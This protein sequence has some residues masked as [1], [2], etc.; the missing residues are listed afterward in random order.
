MDMKKYFCTAISTLCTLTILTSL[1]LFANQRDSF[2]PPETTQTT[3]SFPSQITRAG[4]TFTPNEKCLYVT[5]PEEKASLPASPHIFTDIRE[6]LSV[7]KNGTEDQP[8]RIMIAPSVYWLD[9]PDDP[10]I[11][12]PQGKSATPYAITVDCPHLHLIGLSDRPE[13]VVLAV[14]RGQTQGAVGNYTM[15][16]LKGDGLRAENITF[17]N[18]CNVDLDYPSNPRLNRKKR[19]DAIVQAQLV[20]CAGSDRVFVRNCRFISRLNLCPFVGTRRAL[21]DRCYFECTDDALSGSAVYYRCRFTLFSS[22]P[23]YGTASTGAV[24]LDC[25]LYTHTR[26]QQYLTKVPGVVSMIDCRWHTLYDAAHSP[27]QISWTRDASSIV[28]YQHNITLNGTPYIIDG[29]RQEGNIILKNQ[30]ILKAYKLSHNGN[31]IYNLYNLLS[32]DDGWDPLNQYPLISLIETEQGESLSRIPTLLTISPSL[33]HMEAQ[34]QTEILESKYFLWGNFPATRENHEMLTQGYN[35]WEAAGVLKIQPRDFNTAFCSSQNHFYT[36][37]DAFVSMTADCGLQG[38]TM[39][40]LKPHLK[41]APKLVST[42]TISYE[43]KRKAITLTYAL[44]PGSEDDCS[45]VV[46][47]K[48]TNP[49]QMDTI[50]V[51]HG[52]EGTERLFY[53]ISRA[54]RGY[55]IMAAI[56]PR[57]RDTHSGHTQYVIMQQPITDK[58]VK[59]DLFDQHTLHTDFAEIPCHYQPQILP[60]FWTFDAHKP[61]DTRDYDWTPNPQEA[62]RY[63]TAPDNARGQGLVQQSRGA[64]LFYTPARKGCG[65]MRVRWVMDPCKSGGQGFGSATGQY[66]DLYI[67]MNAK[68]LTGFGLRIERTPHHDRAVTFTLMRYDHGQA[69]PL[70]A[71][72]P[73]ACFRSSCT[74]ELTLRGN[75]LT[76]TAE[77]T[78]PLDTENL[79]KGVTLSVSLRAEI[80]PGDGTSIGLQHTGSVGASATLIHHVEAEWK[81]F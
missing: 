65:D 11:R 38:R 67:K 64:R 62:W 35:R 8:M 24:F 21:F 60:G 14:N 17:G 19:S 22:K 10:A 44:T 53:P 13:E 16:L 68:T 57:R 29:D 34:G 45:H 20:H 25:D 54:D 74:I 27:L 37:T 40:R 3:P 75:H 18:Y 49:D 69:T 59:W 43:K 32:A 56:T 6:A 79:S 33:I 51:K 72:Q 48:L 47:Y 80:E 12:R 7:V 2:S 39:I 26:T 31:T 30:P 36:P 4:Y 28:C 71:P 55:Y 58:Q 66:L 15:M 50:A 9:N 61:A 1:P 63:G 23:F 41:E 42:P 5:T 81:T 52:S 76:A 73:S 46:W 70:S 78:A 77:T